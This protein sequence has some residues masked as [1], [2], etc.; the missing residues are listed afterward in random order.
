M[1]IGELAT[2]TGTT[3]RALRH[4]EQTGPLTST[5]AT[6][7]YRAYPDAAVTRV[8]NT[9]C[10]LAVGLTLEDVREFEPC[11][12]GDVLTAPPSERGLRVAHDRLAAPDRRIAA[13]TDTRT[14]L[15]AA[16]ERV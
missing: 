12:D 2:A 16:L 14:R 9:R 6:N 8:G 10:L 3:P 7:G 15:A 1:L 5:R 13:H 4:Y 11:L